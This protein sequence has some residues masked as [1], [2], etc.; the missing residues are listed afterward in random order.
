MHT[1]A[2]TKISSQAEDGSATEL[3][4]PRISLVTPVWN[5]GKYIEQTI[6]SVLAQAYPNLEYFIVD[7]GS[8]D[9][10]LDIIR[11]YEGKISGWISEPDKGMYDALNK[12]F[13]R[14]SG[15][16]MGWISATDQLQLGG[17]SVVG[18]VFRDL[19]PVEWITGRPT[20]INEH[21]MTI[22]VLG[23]TR[24]SRTRF[25]AG[26]N[27]VIQQESTYWRRSLWERAGSH[28]DSSRR[29]GADFE[30]WVRF[31]RHAQIYPVDA[32]IGA[33]RL[34]E[35][36]LFLQNVEECYR[37]YEDYIDAELNSAPHGQWLRVFRRIGSRAETIPILRPIWKR[38]VMDRLY[39]RR[40]R[41]WPPVIEY[42]TN[43][44][45]FRREE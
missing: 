25:L 20:Q 41:D 30:L 19:P 39:F 18:S 6:R 34:H 43:K 38:Q 5:S 12:G 3:Q 14:T 28:T 4:W 44:W 31:F 37:I 42:R 22:S 40:G 29:N 24:W 15:E 35:D 13:A 7:G 17:L 23:Q 16:I 33:F 21:G 26:A 45:D 1:T 10:T 9:G 36:S 27:R 11:K 8:T 2:E 32:L